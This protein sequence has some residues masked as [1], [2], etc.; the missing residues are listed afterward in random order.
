MH[1]LF[2]DH[3]TILHY[4]EQGKIINNFE[5]LMIQAGATHI[6]QKYGRFY[7]LQIIRWLSF[8]IA[9]LSRIGAYEHRIAPLLGLDEPF[10]IFS[11]DDALLKERKRWSIYRP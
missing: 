5:A 9:D 10:V 4:D 8:L 1:A 3:A 2:A 6:V 11:N 7:T